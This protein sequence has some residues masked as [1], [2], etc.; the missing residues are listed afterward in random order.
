MKYASL[1]GILDVV[2]TSSPSESKH[3]PKN[4][5]AKN[6][7][8]NFRNM[9]RSPAKLDAVTTSSAVEA[10]HLLKDYSNK[11]KKTIEIRHALSDFG[12]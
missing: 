1:V 3:L 12:T 9:L 4:Y 10:K 7:K 2:T 8:S 11:N 6:L 5:S